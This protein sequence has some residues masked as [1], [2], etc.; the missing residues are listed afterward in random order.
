MN[1]AVGMLVDVQ[2]KYLDWYEATVT[3]IGDADVAIHYT[4]WSRKFDETIAVNSPR[5]A[6]HGTFVYVGNQTFQLKQRLDVFDQDRRTYQWTTATVIQLQKNWV[7]VHFRGF[8]STFDEWVPVT[9][10]RLAPFGKF[11]RA[12]LVH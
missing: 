6:P 3:R 9:S 8:S 2:D 4:Y 7:K 10:W 1:L 12:R 5:I 11:T